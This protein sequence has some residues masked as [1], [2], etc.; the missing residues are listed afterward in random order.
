MK[1]IFVMSFILT[2]IQISI[3]KMVWADHHEKKH[4]EHAAHKHGHGH[5]SIAFDKTIGTIQL[6][7]PSESVIGFEHKAIKD[8]DKKIQQ[9]VFTI[10]ESKITDLVSFD[11][12]IN[13]KI[14]KSK[15][16]MISDKEE[17]HDGGKPLHGEHSEVVANYDVV[18]EKS[19]L[20]TKIIFNWQKYFKK[21][22]ELDVQILIDNL[23]K[24]ME[25]K[26]AGES[27]YLK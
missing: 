8:A 18:C 1:I 11:S 4:R 9:N 21:I 27:L 7:V 24:S 22:K 26:K 14:K 23:Q 3:P 17:A 6:N 25:L 19:P 13:C 20:G 5:L 10:L 15:I 2:V 16:E 12:K